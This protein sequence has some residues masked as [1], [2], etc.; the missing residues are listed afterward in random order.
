MGIPIQRIIENLDRSF[1]RKD[2]DAAENLLKYWNSEAEKEN[3][4]RARLTVLNEQIGFYR[5][6]EREAECLEAIE[7][8][9]ELSVKTGL[10]ST[11]S[12]G[13]TLVNAATGYKAFGKAEK[14]LPLY[15]KARELYENNLDENDSRLGGLYNNMALTVSQL[16]DY[17]KAEMLFNKALEVMRKVPHGELEEA[18]TYCNLADLVSAEKGMLEG[19]KQ[20]S[21][22]LEKA[23]A[24]FDA[25][26]LERDGYYAFVCEKCAPTFSYYGWFFAEREISRRAEEI[27]ERS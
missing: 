19:E 18:I 11:V 1:A 3:D 6:L 21:E 12:Y 9:L 24:L 15:E 10:A 14:A 4:L 7:A 8:A 27:Y 22:Y 5:K 26:G 23:I 2:F 16:G 25:D 13:T 20:I 17:R